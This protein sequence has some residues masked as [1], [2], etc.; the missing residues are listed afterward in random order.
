MNKKVNV[1]TLVSE[2]VKELETKLNEVRE[3][4]ELSFVS[5]KEDDGEMEKVREIMAIESVLILN[6]NLLSI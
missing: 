2:R 6:Q 3:K 5:E 4:H 1:R